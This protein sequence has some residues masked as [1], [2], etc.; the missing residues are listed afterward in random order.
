AVVTGWMQYEKFRLDGEWQI[1]TCTETA[2]LSTYE[3]LHLAWR[4]FLSDDPLSAPVVGNGEKVEEAFQTIAP[5]GRFPVSFVGTK[6]IN[7]VSLTGR[8]EGARRASTG[9]FELAPT[10][11]RR[12]WSGY[13]P[14]YQRNVNVLEGTFALTAGNARGYARA[15]R[16]IEG[17][18]VAAD[19]FI[20]HGAMPA[21]TDETEPTAAQAIES[22]GAPD[23]EATP[24]TAPSEQD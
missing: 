12:S 16:L 17:E 5:R 24:D 3:G 7:R 6:E 2:D 23:A 11:T 10:L 22:T 15:V 13:L 8:F 19:P 9:R 18:P 21:E 1:D 20:C 4:V 14:F